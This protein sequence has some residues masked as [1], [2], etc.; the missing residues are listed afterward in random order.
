MQVLH[1]SPKLYVIFL[2]KG[3][4]LRASLRQFAIENHVTSAWLNAVGTLK[5][6]KLNFYRRKKRKFESKVFKG[7]WDL[8]EFHG[9]ISEK[10]G[11]P[12]VHIHASIKRGERE[13]KLAHLCEAR[14][15]AP[16]EIHV[17]LIDD[18]KTARKKEAIKTMCPI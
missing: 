10:H 18:P 3:E 6:P 16:V 2:Y 17:H 11:K 8:A 9:S 13:S 7:R 5:K 14:V 12:R 1:D 15:I 4:K